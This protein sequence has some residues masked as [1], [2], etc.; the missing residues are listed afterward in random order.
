M[1]LSG[2]IRRQPR[3]LLILEGLIIVAVA[4]ILDRITGQDLSFLL[5]YIIPVY[6]FI[7]FTTRRLG[8]F[9]SLVCAFLWF[10]SN[11]IDNNHASHLRMPYLNMSIELVFF[12]LVTYLLCTLKEAL[13]INEELGRIDLLTGAM[14][15]SAFYDF[16]GKEIDRLSR[17]KRPFTVANVDIDNFKVVNYR[18]GYPIGDKL[19]YSVAQTIKAN[20]RKVDVVSRFG[21]DEFAVLLPETGAEAAQAVLSRIRN[22]LLNT[23]EQNKWPVT[24]SFGTVTFMKAPISV[25]EMM[26]KVAIVMYAAKDSGMN[27]IEQEIINA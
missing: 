2:Y 20:L 27:T 16:A 14:N 24:F 21:G 4:F 6:F 5:F 13:G 19:L 18:F 23:M 22:I 17:Y 15:R 7:W 26:K 12:F 1:P 25:E 9:I 11:I 10:S 3:L 8:V